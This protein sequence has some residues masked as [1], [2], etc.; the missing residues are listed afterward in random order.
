MLCF[1]FLIP[2]TKSWVTIATNLHPTMFLC[3]V[4]SANL[5][6][7]LH[8]LCFVQYFLSAEGPESNQ[9]LALCIRS[10]FYLPLFLE[11]V[12]FKVLSMNSHNRLHR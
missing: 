4:A 6:T 5:T 9:P 3:M 10:I 11:F 7:L 1:V 8:E 2:K 12:V